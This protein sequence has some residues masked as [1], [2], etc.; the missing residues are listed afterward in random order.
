M[1][2]VVHG[3]YPLTATSGARTTNKEGDM[4]NRRFAGTLVAIAMLGLLTGPARGAQEDVTGT[5]TL[6][7]M[8]VAAGLGYSWGR[9]ILEYRGQ[10]YP[11]TV[12]G[13]SIVDVG[14]AK[15]VARGEVYNLKNAVDFEGTFMA[16]DVGATFG[17]GAGAAAMLNQNNVDMVWTA[18]N[19]GLSFSLAHAGI[20]V[21][22]TDEARA[23]AARNR[24]SPSDEQPAAAPRPTQ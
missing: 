23:L 3:A 24:R 2:H 9:G 17:G 1:A 14:V 16:A 18:T 21:K 4:G 13:F 8:S 19:Q 20:N 7:T 6:E 5:I 11:F 15:R 10:Q 12:N 22:F